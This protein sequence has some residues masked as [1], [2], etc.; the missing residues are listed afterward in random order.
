MPSLLLPG[1]SSK[2]GAERK[3]GIENL[4]FSMNK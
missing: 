1:L 2:P 4:S 3:N